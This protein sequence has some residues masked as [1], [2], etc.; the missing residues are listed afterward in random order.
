MKILNI[1]TPISRIENLPILYNNVSYY[2]KNVR[3]IWWVILDNS[4]RKY[5]KNIS[6]NENADL[7]IKLLVSH[8]ANALA[9]HAHRNVILDLLEEDTEEWVYNLDDDNVLHPDFINFFINDGNLDDFDVALVSQ[10]LFDGRIRLQADVNSVK[11]N[12]V[13]TAM[14]LFKVKA[15]NGHLRYT[16]DY[17]A[18]GL[19]IE[20]L[21][22]NTNNKFYI[23]DSPL[24]YYNYLRDTKYEFL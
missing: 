20:A 5:Y 6:L 14:C 10:I 11:V 4:C 7:K 18:D 22:N 16:E 8:Y 15:L 21:Y 9:G 12:H 23:K 3:I 19:F 13:D 17:C 24:C 2:A 1:I